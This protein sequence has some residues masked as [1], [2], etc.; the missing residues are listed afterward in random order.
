MTAR[1]VADRLVDAALVTAR[2]TSIGAAPVATKLKPVAR[3]V[4]PHLVS[5]A[6]WTTDSAFALKLRWIVLV[7]AVVTAVTGSRLW[8]FVS[9]RLAGHVYRQYRYGVM[10]GKEVAGGGLA[11]LAE[12]REAMDLGFPWTHR[13]YAYLLQSKARDR[14]VRTRLHDELAALPPQLR[15][16]HKEQLVAEATERF[17]ARRSEF[18]HF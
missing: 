3:K 11:N 9:G 7:T 1:P 10:L 14:F 17:S 2:I 6:R 4:K 15:L 13:Q 8:M 16:A 12:H 18:I 5:A